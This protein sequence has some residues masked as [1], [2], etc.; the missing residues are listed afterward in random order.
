MYAIRSY[1]GMD[2]SSS[3]AIYG[4]GNYSAYIQG[5]MNISS[6]GSYTSN[7]ASYYDVNVGTNGQFIANGTVKILGNPSYAIKSGYSSGTATVTLAGSNN[8][9]TGTYVGIYSTDGTV[10]ISGTTTIA[11]TSA[12]SKA[13]NLSYNFV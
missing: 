10:N 4:G 13:L 8:K 9:L 3:L 6:T 1:Y 2:V 5:T 7:V 12:A 11:L